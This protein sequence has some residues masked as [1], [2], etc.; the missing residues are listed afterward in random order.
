MSLSEI[1]GSLSDLQESEPRKNS[2]THVR[3]AIL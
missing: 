3:A 2:P 1:A